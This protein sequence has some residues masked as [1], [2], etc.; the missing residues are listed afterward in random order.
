[1]VVHKTVLKRVSRLFKPFIASIKSCL[2]AVETKM[3]LSEEDDA[4][5]DFLHW[6][7]VLSN[8]QYKSKSKIKDGLYCK[9]EDKNFIIIIITN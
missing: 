8:V 3:S 4:Y 1:M 9:G 6:L 2:V 7:I 5:R